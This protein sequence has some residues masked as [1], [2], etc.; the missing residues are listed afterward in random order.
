M[1]KIHLY[2]AIISVVFVA[3]A[4]SD[5]DNPDTQPVDQNPTITVDGKD[6]TY[7][8]TITDLDIP[9]YFPDADSTVITEEV[10]QLGRHLFYER[11][12]SRNN[13]VSCASCHQQDKAFTDGRAFSVGL[14]GEQTAR[15]AMAIVNLAFEDI[16]FWDGRSPSLE[17]QALQPIED[18]IEMDLTL[19]EAIARLDSIY[20]Y[21]SLFFHAYGDTIVSAQKIARALATFERGIIS[22]DSKFDKYKRG[23]ASL[24]PEEQLGLNLFTTHP[25]TYWDPVNQINIFRRGGNCGDCHTTVLFS[26]LI[27]NQGMKNNGLEFDDTR[28]DDGYFGVTGKD[29]DRGKFKT[30]SLRNIELT[31]PYMHDGR[32]NT[33][34][35]VLDHYNDHVKV[36]ST[37]DILMFVN[38]D[39]QQ[40][41]IISPDGKFIQLGL[42]QNEK[43]AIVA[44][45]KTLTDEELIVNP[46]YSNPFTEQ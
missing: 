46:R 8:P 12:L 7:S 2:I 28:T 38:N 3:S 21:D 35:E 19:A 25:G 33:L 23:E 18:H 26:K 4:C 1:K 15:G 44:F 32:F 30:P 24:S 20:L 16:F 40:Q 37:L 31:A 34:E 29:G 22:K 36:S 41:G 27:G 11:R 45:L 42:T 5:D 39:P 13:T 6:W 17:D 14:N 10:F 9:L 43:D